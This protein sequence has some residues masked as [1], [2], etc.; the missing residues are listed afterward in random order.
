MRGV[1]AQDD[2]L[3]R[4]AVERRLLTKEQLAAALAEQAEHAGK[5]LGEVLQSLR[6]VTEAQ[7]RQ[8][9][10]EIASAQAATLKD[11]APNLV[12]KPFARFTVREKLGKG[13]MGVVYKAWDPQHNRHVAIKCMLAADDPTELQRFLR[14]AST[15]TQLTHTNIVAVY[16]IDEF[17]GTPYI[18]M[19]LVRG[20]SLSRLLNPR[21]S[22]EKPLPLRDALA[23]VRDVAR[24]LNYAHERGIVHRDVKPE[25]VMVDERRRAKLMDFGLAREVA[26]GA[27]LTTTGHVMGTPYYMSPEQ[28]IGR[29]E[30][31]DHRTDIWALGVILY[32][33]GTRRLPFGGEAAA[34]VLHRI[35]H[36]DLVAPRKT[37]PN[38]PRPLETIVLKCLE[39]E[40]DRRYATAGALADDLDR[41]LAGRPVTARRASVAYRLRRKLARRKALVGVSAICLVVL[42]I[43][44]AVILPRL[45]RA[46]RRASEAH[47]AA[48]E[49]LRRTTKAA[50]SAALGFRQMGRLAEMDQYLKQVEEACRQ[51]SQDMPTLAEPHYRMGRMYRARMMDAEALAAQNKALSKEAGYA[52]ALY[53]RVVLNARAFRAR[54][55]ELL[56]DAWSR[57]GARLAQ[58]SRGQIVAGLTMRPPSRDELI[59][60]DTRAQETLKTLET[61]LRRLEASHEGLGDGELA[62]ARGLHLW[63]S[64]QHDAARDALE[65]AVQRTPELEE[66]YEALGAIADQRGQ[67][68]EA[69]RWRSAG[70]ERDRGYLPHLDGRAMTHLMAS[71]TL[72]SRGEDASGRFQAAIDDLTEA[73]RR[74]PG[75]A[76]SLRL[77]G[78]VRATCASHRQRRGDDPGQLYSAAIEDLD[79]A[80][81]REPSHSAAMTWRGDARLNWGTHLLGTTGDSEPLFKAAIEDFGKAV[82]VASKREDAWVRRGLAHVNWALDRMAR[83][84]KRPS[85]CGMPS[86][87]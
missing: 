73:L 70:I 56:D 81:A 85:S 2:T 61:D 47:E 29:R 68:D 37:D 51:A 10:D 25:N 63:V 30:A 87:I 19:E 57:E 34:E 12:G 80:L 40:A 35:V 58:E 9:H 26:R 78:Y 76:A 21:S 65:Q 46:Q 84:R 3:G 38:M 82:K 75:R 55:Q 6:L 33:I 1:R 79:H 22:D 15:A 72:E 86:T 39:Y 59:A 54:V 64:G 11:V 66:A 14:E 43:A 44:A 42:A 13:G 28:A 5:S 32:E 45:G 18:V 31:V 77:R 41:Y 74:E 48:L 27:T 20:Q 62:C 69:I 71:L 16:E 83:G 36:E 50:L 49:Q 24:A 60:G 17:E 23:I 53:E 4:L 52:P 7:L 8:L 67:Y